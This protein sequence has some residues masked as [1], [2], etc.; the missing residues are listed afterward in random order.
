METFLRFLIT[1]GAMILGFMLLISIIFLL[2]L[3]YI[4]LKKVL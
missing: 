3:I 2:H 4:T 1:G